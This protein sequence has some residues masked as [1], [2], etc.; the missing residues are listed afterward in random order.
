MAKKRKTAAVLVALV[1][2][3][4]IVGALVLGR[5]TASC[6]PQKAQFNLPTGTTYSALLD[7]LEANGV[8]NMSVVALVGKLR[9]LDQS[10]KPGHYELAAGSSAMGIVT[11]LRSGAQKP[12]KLTFNNILSL[13]ICNIKC[14]HIIYL[15]NSVFFSL[16]YCPSN[17]FSTIKIK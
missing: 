17:I 3:I 4:G 5:A 1:A 15:I 14:T 7:T 9:K 11:T 6:L 16:S 2:I 12:V 13:F 8:E 10:V